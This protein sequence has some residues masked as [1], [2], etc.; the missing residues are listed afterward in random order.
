MDSGGKWYVVRT[1]TLAESR[2]TAHLNNQGFEVYLPRYCKQRRHAR[3]VDTVLRPLFPGYIFVKID[4]QTQQWR[5]INGTVGVISIV[6]FGMELLSIDEAIIAN[7]RKRED[8]TGGVSL[9]ISGLKKGDKIRVNEGP[10]EDYTGLLEETDDKN[11]AILLL[12]LMG[13]KVRVT[14]P[15]ENLT[16]A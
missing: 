4:T 7:L 14:A 16:A 1:Q 8:E 15:L 9:V 3:K 13:R 10:F 5:S 11:R 2:A 12:D 6:Q